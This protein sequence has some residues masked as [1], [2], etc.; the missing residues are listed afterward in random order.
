[1]ITLYRRFVRLSVCLSA[2]ALETTIHGTYSHTYTQTHNEADT[3]R[4]QIDGAAHPSNSRS[5]PPAA[6]AAAPEE[7]RG[8][9]KLSSAMSTVYNSYFLQFGKLDYNIGGGGYLQFSI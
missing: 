4:H 5:A 7:V 1:V 8:I 3:I 9:R 6:A 2:H